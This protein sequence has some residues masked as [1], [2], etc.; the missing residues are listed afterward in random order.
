MNRATLL[1][2]V[3][4]LLLSSV[5]APAATPRVVTN[6]L[7]MKLAP[8]AAGQ[9]QMGAEATLRDAGADE[10]PIHPVRLSR[11]FHIGVH[12]V[13]QEEFRDGISLNS[14]FL[15]FKFWSLEW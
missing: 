5:P 1:A 10:R 4:G 13:T 8:I 3:S 15:R 6:S 14:D 7:G 9:F 2:A 11:P 12:E